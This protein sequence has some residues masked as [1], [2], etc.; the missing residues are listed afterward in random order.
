MCGPA[1]TTSAAPT[2]AASACQNQPLY[3]VASL[4]YCEQAKEQAVPGCLDTHVSVRRGRMRTSVI[5]LPHAPGCALATVIIAAHVSVSNCAAVPKAAQSP[6]SSYDIIYLGR[7]MMELHRCSQGCTRS[8]S[9]LRL[10]G[11][12]WHLQHQSGLLSIISQYCSNDGV[13]KQ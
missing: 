8:Q 7:S 12:F 2:A 6:P 10:H 9:W 11:C 1:Q 13:A 5:R 3:M 4:P